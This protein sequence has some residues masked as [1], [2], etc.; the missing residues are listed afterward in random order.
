MARDFSLSVET[1]FMNHVKTRKLCRLL[2]NPMAFGHLIALWAWAVE[3]APDGDLSGIDV[4]EIESGAGYA[5]AD[6]ACYRALVDAGFVD[7]GANGTRSLHNWMEP[8]RTGYAIQQL[9][10]ERAR[11]RRSKGIKAA[12]AAPT[13]EPRGVPAEAPQDSTGTPAGI[14]AESSGNPVPSRFT[15]HGSEEPVGVAPAQAR[16]LWAA[17]DWL[18][19]FKRAWADRYR[20]LTYG[21]TSD[22]KAC[23][24]L[25]DFL[26]AM[27]PAA[28]SAAQDRAPKL[29]AAFLGD[30][31]PAAVKARHPFAFFVGRFG[32]LLTDPIRTKAEAD[33]RCNLHRQAGTFRQ[34]PR[35][36]P[37]TGCPTCKENAAARG[38]R[39]SDPTPVAPPT[40]KPPPEWTDEQKAELAEA[41]R[42]TTAPARAAGGAK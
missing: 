41:V 42:G 4:P 32:G 12:H 31:S 36:G 37:V 21:Q 3:A 26:A 33:P 25:A 15:V 6:G 11:W 16:D 35:G 27:D 2:R 20:T 13:E 39:E 22:G 9:E 29:L 30:E 24:N 34:L 14:R 8:G 38:T 23:G 28:R 10:A 18:K 1:G 7:E 40:L 17:G 5:A 19:L